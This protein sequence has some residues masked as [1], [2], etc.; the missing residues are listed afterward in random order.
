MNCLIE[1]SVVGRLG[2]RMV[3]HNF[4]FLSELLFLTNRSWSQVKKILKG[5]Y[6]NF[7]TTTG[8]IDQESDIFFNSNNKWGQKIL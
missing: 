2:G 8:I 6:V 5:L 1:Q 7:A 3:S 4:N